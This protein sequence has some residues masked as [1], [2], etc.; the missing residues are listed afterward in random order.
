MYARYKP[1]KC[2]RLTDTVVLPAVA[3]KISVKMQI[4]DNIWIEQGVG[5]QKLR[6]ETGES[7]SLASTRQGKDSWSLGD[8]KISSLL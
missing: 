3:A 6:R 4:K 7:L 8:R 2:L 5:T 1:N